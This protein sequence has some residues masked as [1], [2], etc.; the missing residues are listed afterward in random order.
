VIIFF[1]LVIL[2]PNTSVNGVLASCYE[3]NKFLQLF[4]SFSV[5]HTAQG[6]LWSLLFSLTSLIQ[7][8]F[9]FLLQCAISS[10][11]KFSI[12]WIN[13]IVFIVIFSSMFPLSFCSLN[14]LSLYLAF[15]QF[16]Y[17][18]LEH[19]GVH[20][21]AIIPLTSLIH[22]LAPSI[23]FCGNSEVYLIFF[24]LL[25]SWLYSCLKNKVKVCNWR[26]E[27]V[28]RS[29]GYQ[30]QAW[31]VNITLTRFNHYIEQILVESEII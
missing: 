29:S 24:P 14:I 12:S 27:E 30:P 15:A 10:P 31:G 21:F 1:L 7:L 22:S 18:A 19:W 13:V 3:L 2:L 26:K 5:P 20:L 25:N 17:S 6:V 28:T 11:L 16:C 9:Y 8:I 4:L 23:L